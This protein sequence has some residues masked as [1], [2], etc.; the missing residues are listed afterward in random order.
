MVEAK[1]TVTGDEGLA[2]EKNA[3]S[4]KKTPSEIHAGHRERLR[5][6]Y[7][8]GGLEILSDH[9]VLELMLFYCMPRKDTNALAHRILDEFGTIDALFEADPEVVSR[10]C[11]LSLNTSVLISL[12]L[13]LNKRYATAKW[14]KNDIIDSSTTACAFAKGLFIGETDEVMFM[15]CLDAQNH[16]VFP[17]EIARGTIDKAP[18]Y[19]RVIMDRVLK[20]NAV[21]VILAHN[22]PSGS[23]TPSLSDLKVTSFI[24]GILEKIDV[25]VADHIIVSGKGELSFAE[26]KIKS[27]K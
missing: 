8:E 21:S 9:E 13:P 15:I 22:H 2:A 7:L 24:E 18:I 6:K 5:K 10:S 14:S 25:K 26:K 11:G 16:V 17:V 19:P 4:K 27:L 1:H 23:L 12:V 3:R 20:Y